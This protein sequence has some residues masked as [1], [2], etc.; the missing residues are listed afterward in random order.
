[1]GSELLMVPH[2]YSGVSIKSGDYVVIGLPNDF[3]VGVFSKTEFF[4]LFD[5]ADA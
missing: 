4:A 5:P 2:H 1:M 3:T